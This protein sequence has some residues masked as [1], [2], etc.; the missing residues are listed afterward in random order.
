MQALTNWFHRQAR[1]EERAVFLEDALL[2][3]RFPAYAFYRMRFFIGRSLLAAGLHVIEI[4]LLTAAFPPLLVTAAL[5]VRTSTSLAIAGWWGALET[6]R[7]QIRDL[8]RG[9]KSPALSR[10]VAQWLGGAL[11]AAVL[12]LLL[13]AAWVVVEVGIGGH[14]FGLFHFYVVANSV[15]LALSLFIRT[16]HSGVYALRRVYRPLWSLA[17]IDVIGFSGTFLLWPLLGAWGIPLLL[18]ISTLL[19][20]VLTWFF[21]RPFYVGLGLFADR[22]RPRWPRRRFLKTVATPRFVLAGAAYALTKVDS[23]LLFGLSFGAPRSEPVYELFLTFY[24]LGPF[25][26]AASEWAQL[27]YFDLKR[28]ELDLFGN[29]RRLFEGHVNSLAVLVGG[30]CWL[31]ACLAVPLL[32]QQQ[33][34]TLYL[35]LAALLTVRSRLAFSQIRTFTEGRYARLLASGLLIVLGTMSVPVFTT[36]GT[37]R[38]TVFVLLLLVALFLLRKRAKHTRA[39][40]LASQLASALDWVAALQERSDR[41]RVRALELSALVDD[42]LVEQFAR[43]LAKRLADT[44]MVTLLG[45]R[46][47]V[48]WERATPGDKPSDDW[49]NHRGAGL[50]ESLRSTPYLDSGAEA[51][52]HAEGRGLIGSV[53]RAKGLPG[54]V[55]GRLNVVKEMFRD[56]LPEGTL[57]EPAAREDHVLRGL[58]PGERRQIMYGAVYYS[59]NLFRPIRSGRYDVTALLERGDVRLLFIVDKSVHRKRRS[60]WRS[61]INEINVSIAIQENG[62]S[63][64][65]APS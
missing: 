37:A 38:L 56:L 34:R 19:G 63:P 55:G 59:R 45:S 33:P 41:L 46:R 7:E 52:R 13:A 57:Y 4:L 42:W 62:E 58:S 31:L 49:I 40:A 17:V 21:V 23:I 5:V 14:A 2:S 24:V 16:L 32:P 53:N 64:C 48:W 54:L 9:K 22:V 28:Y 12:V 35:L 43:C 39:C 30:V 18:L 65:L 11:L 6:M 26:R 25:V 50:I 15:R 47:I 51:L 36:I 20:S 60:V 44:G 29:F 8:R 10:V 3:G 61:L 27:Y 1:K